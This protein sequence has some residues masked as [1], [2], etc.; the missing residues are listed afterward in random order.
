M[1][2]KIQLNIITSPEK[3]IGSVE[4]SVYSQIY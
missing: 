2:K 4:D 3:R 1:V